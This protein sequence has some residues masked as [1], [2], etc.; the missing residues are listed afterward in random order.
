[1]NAPRPLRAIAWTLVAVALSLGAARDAHAGPDE[2]RR[3]A[4]LHAE[5]IALAKQRKFNDAVSRFEASLKLNPHPV[6]MHNLGRAW[7]ALGDQAQAWDYLAR[8]LESDPSYELAKD[9]R[10]MLDRISAN[11]VK[12]HARV[13]VR[14]TP[15]SAKV[16]L[17]HP[18]RGLR[19]FAT[20]PFSTWLRAGTSSVDLSHP[21]FR[22]RQETLTLAAGETRE[23]EYVLVPRP[24]LGFLRVSVNVPNAQVLLSGRQLGR[25][26]L[27]V[28]TLE[29][30][31]YQL[32]VKASGF[33]P[34]VQPITVVQDAQT[35]VA[36]TLEPGVGR[37]GAGC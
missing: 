32:E 2:S 21:E 22:G 27:D 15:S 35:E 18:E 7:E 36:V 26:P 5:G 10:A 25:A 19:T 23:L 17:S 1:M 4:E 9:G 33:E 31:A 20:S 16:A 24:R 30:G 13:T 11:L 34:F 3:A 29:T 6:T 12:D 8:A 37:S 28:V 14:V